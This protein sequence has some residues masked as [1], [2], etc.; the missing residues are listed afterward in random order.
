M[1]NTR[2]VLDRNAH[3]AAVI[4]RSVLALVFALTLTSWFT[5]EAAAQGSPTGR[6]PKL[7]WTQERQVVWNRMKSDYERNPTNP[8]TLGGQWYKVVK[9]NAENVVYGPWNQTAIWPTLMFQWTGDRRWAKIAWERVS[10]HFLPM[11]AAEMRG[12]FGREYAIEHVILLDWLWPALSPSER[13]QYMNQ[14]GAMLDASLGADRWNSEGYSPVDSDQTVG[15]YFGVVLFFLTHPEHPRAR[16]WYNFVGSDSNQVGTGGLSATA[17]DRTTA[18]NTIRDYT[19]MAAGGEWI[20]SAAYNLGTVDLLLLGY[21]AVRTATPVEYF[22]EIA[23]WLPDVA[24][25]QVAYWTPDLA[26]FYQW[27]DEEHPREAEQTLYK[28]TNLDGMIAGLL[29]GTTEGAQL[30]GQLLDLISK[31]GATGYPSMQPAVTGRLFFFFNPYARASD[32]RTEKTFKATGM[33]VLIHRSGFSPEDSLFAANLAART[34]TKLVDHFGHYFNDFELWRKGEWVLT[35]PRGYMGAPLLGP[36]ANA[37]L[38]QGFGDMVEFKEPVAIA[39][40]DKYAYI[41]GTTGGAAFELPYYDPPQ[42]FVHEWTRSLIYL[43]GETDAVIAY[44]RTHVTDVPRPERYYPAVQSL[45]LNAPAAKQW[46]LHMPVA[47]KI[48][49]STVSWLSERRQSVQWSVLLPLDAKMTL[50][51]E[52]LLRDNGESIWRDYID[53]AE[54]KY[55]VKVIPSA[56]NPWDAFLNVIQVGRAGDLELITQPGEVEGVR[57][58]RPGSSDV[59]A[60]FNARPSAPLAPE[61]YDRS[62]ATA[63]RRAHLRDSGYSVKW[64]SRAGTTDVYLADLDPDKTWV[65]ELDGRRGPEIVPASSLP[66]ITV[67]GSGFHTLRLIAEEK[68]GRSLN[69]PANPLGR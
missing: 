65:I 33:G 53:P 29:Q 39:A 1:C 46:I 55:H 20:E 12:N 13:E 58:S 19:G 27:G 16:Y 50:Y 41:A 67:N 44:D 57:L 69:G 21:E 36:G 54:L 18:R 61:A 48:S 31:Y 24:K 35:H 40:G 22:P 17:A 45:F 37:V 25:R 52:R 49:P 15:I 26:Q 56:K 47:P 6:Q 32:W 23:S 10:D 38:M 8:T 2:P 11:G 42:V 28:W 51:D 3:V 62:H 9:L 68:S 59:V 63:L 34:D 66:S 60:L 14:I 64:N 43:P 30:Q 7:L 4:H 5:K